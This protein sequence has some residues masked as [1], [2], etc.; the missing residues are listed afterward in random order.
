MAKE[1]KSKTTQGEAVDP[2]SALLGIGEILPPRTMMLR[3]HVGEAVIGKLKYEMSTAMAGMPIIRSNKTGKLFTLSWQTI[4]EL[5][6]KA[7]VDA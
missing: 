7:G 5:A 1:R 2:A 3:I 6:V 4:L